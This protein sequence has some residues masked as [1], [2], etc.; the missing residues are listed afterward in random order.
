MYIKLWLINPVV[1]IFSCVDHNGIEYR[2][3]DI[4]SVKVKMLKCLPCAP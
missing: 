1:A 4:K 3:I 2:N